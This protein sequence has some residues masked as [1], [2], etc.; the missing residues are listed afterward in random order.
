MIFIFIKPA[1]KLKLYKMHIFELLRQSQSR[2]ESSQASVVDKMIIEIYNTYRILD[3]SKPE[4]WDF[5]LNNPSQY[6]YFKSN[7]SKFVNCTTLHFKPDKYK[8][9][10]EILNGKEKQIG[11]K[12][13]LLKHDWIHTFMGILGVKSLHNYKEGKFDPLVPNNKVENLIKFV[14]ANLYHIKNAFKCRNKANDLY[15]RQQI[16]K[17]LNNSVF[18]QY[19]SKLVMYDKKKKD[20]GGSGGRKWVSDN[21]AL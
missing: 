7:R 14:R 16:L 13:D 11:D 9:Y 2:V 5:I 18:G 10:F 12:D 19:G 3:R 21:Y 8:E 20:I 6:K 4:T 17:F 1:D 15:D